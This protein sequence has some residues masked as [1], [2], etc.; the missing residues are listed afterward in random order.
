[1]SEENHNHDLSLD[2]IFS[3]LKKDKKGS[4]K[5]VG[6][7]FKFLDSYTLGDK[8]I[9]FG[10]EN[11]TDEIY[12]KLYSGKL[13]LVYGKSGTGKSSIVNCGLISK[14]PEEDIF[15][16]NI[17]CGKSPYN[18]FISGIRKYSK[19]DR[20]RP[21]EI[22]EDIFYEYSKPIAL[23]FDQF[24][25]IF[26]LSNKDERDKLASD[27][28]QLLKSRLKINIIL[29]IREEFFANLT[30][31]EAFIPGLYDNRT[32]IERMSRSAAKRAITEPCKACNVGIEEGLPDKI[33]DH[34]IVQSDGLELTWLQI[35]LDKM[36]RTALDRDPEKP[37]ISFDDLAKL[38]RMGNVLSE[39][40]DE[41]IRLMPNGEMGEAVLKTMISTDGT[42]KQVQLADITE[43]LRST[44]HDLGQKKIGEI[45]LYF[46]RVRIITD[47][48]EQGYYELRHDAIA[49][50]IYERMT[51]SE[52]E[53][54]EIKT[55]LDNSYKIYIKRKV[56]LSTNDLK[57][58]AIYES[59]LILSKELK[60]FIKTSKKEV[61]RLK[62]RRR[63]VALIAVVAL[64]I[65]LSGFTIWA[66]NERS[67]ALAQSKIAEGQKNEA[68]IANADAENARKAA[69][70]QKDKAEANEELALKQQKIAEEQRQEAI[71]ANRKTDVAR[72]QA[73]E[74][75]NKAEANESLA[76]KAKEESEIAR[77]EA[78]RAQNEA[79][80][81]L[82]QF[83]GKELAN[84]SLIMEED[85][86]LKAQLALS[87][88]DLVTH[89]YNNFSP[90]GTPISYDNEILECLQRAYLQ[91]ESD[92]L[93]TGE[94]WAI[95]SQGRKIVYSHQPGHLLVATL[96]IQD[97]EKL[98]EL[99]TGSSI[100]LP[101]LSL[102]RG[103]AFNQ[104]DDKI[105][106]GT[107]D[108]NV[109]LLDLVNSDQADPELLYQHE[110]NR[111]LHLAFVPGKEWLVSSSTDKTIQVWDYEQGRSIARIKLNE[112]V[113]KFV[114]IN[115][116]QLV[117]TNSRGQIL[118][119]DLQ[120]GGNEPE[121]LYTQSSG[122]ALQSLAYNENH[123]WI[124]TS[125]FGKLMVFPLDQEKNT[126]LKPESFIVKH[127]AMIAQL[128]FS[129]DNRWLV[130]ASKDAI[131]LWDLKDAGSK[132]ADKY[133]PIVIENNHM[134]FSLSFDQDSKYLLW[135]DNRL[136]HL[137]PVDIDNTYTKLKL[138]TQ[139][140]EL[141][142]QEWNYYV[143][144]DLER[145]E[146][147]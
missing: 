98:P 84:K 17:R 1:M 18:N 69:L 65:I 109:T 129:P 62:Q 140:K 147:K 94:I 74:E 75:K 41:Q 42:K 111:V 19:T 133:V 7:P 99:L 132:E 120:D 121:V 14:I 97:P 35:I 136:L 24:E 63:N 72:K 36:F 10:R 68:I 21:V 128:E 88:H 22:L 27:F 134:I 80:F 87:A 89:G 76:V 55:F 33:L 131:M 38:G 118:V 146:S 32:R 105:A 40:L 112:A 66:V 16:I 15:P 114:L 5:K 6:V 25:E 4:R 48:D 11:E 92:S 143:K 58:I 135:G 3:R 95:G 50:R 46:V 60:D 20:D 113:Q 9:F 23:I 2:D 51:A 49:S 117:Y 44:G 28:F 103:I 56:L 91:F 85:R 53:L 127:K 61:Q 107:L 45:L 102:V 8:N 57:Y 34:L 64:M 137:Y 115:Q 93:L 29:V 86:M 12:R 37:V 43:S 116:D 142:E 101:S 59:K 144:G 67:K 110:N 54:V 77:N 78:I 106:C 96:E 145:P 125:S 124:V 108:G 123:K 47:Q 31:F 26:I 100:K 104:R 130:S 126:D 30:E 79:K 83:N 70:E 82:Y 13:I 139:G 81:F 138:V 39:F 71:V 141:N 90:E 122:Q 73:L 119:W 52:K